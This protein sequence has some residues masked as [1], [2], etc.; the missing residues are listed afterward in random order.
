MAGQ[1]DAG[2]DCHEC[3]LTATLLSQAEQLRSAWCQLDE[4]RR[5]PPVRW[6]AMFGLC[7][8]S[9]LAGLVVMAWALSPAVVRWGAG[10]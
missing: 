6:W 1:D 8:T 10:R 2:P 3:W 7:V 4:R 5:I 9:F